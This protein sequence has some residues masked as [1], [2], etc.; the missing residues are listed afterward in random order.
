[1]N[2]LPTDGHKLVVLA[3]DGWND[4]GSAAVDTAKHFIE[5]W[6]LTAAGA[7]ARRDYYDLTVMR[8]H[9]RISEDGPEIQWPD[10]S[11]FAGRLPG[12]EVPVEVL[13]GP[14]PSV[15]WPE[16]VSEI[17][18][19]IEPGD[20]VVILGSLL[21]D[22]SHSR[23]LPV[24]VSADKLALTEDF[25]VDLNDYSGPVGIVG[26]LAVELYDRDVDT[27]SLWVAVPAYAGSAPSP[28]AVLSL[29]NAFEDLTGS[30]VDQ[31]DLVDEAAAWENGTNE[32]MDGDEDLADYVA[33]I[34][35]MTDASELPE[36]SGE[37]IAKEFERY[38][39]RRRR[40]GR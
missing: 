7:L 40:H 33:R 22:V 15:R 32:L 24:S 14:E 35:S 12:T 17:S 23:P 34:E 1:M 6:E 36:A 20:R 3:F 9:V 5:Q 11:R 10:I 39:E 30:V 31:R 18:A 16:F 8:P 2:Y 21:A 29:I 26:V 19:V 4:A 13:V 25:D 28:K 37:A 27:V 38:L